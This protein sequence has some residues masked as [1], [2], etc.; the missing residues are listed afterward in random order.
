MAFAADSAVARRLRPIGDA[1]GDGSLLALRE[2]DEGVTRAVVVGSDGGAHRV[3][4]SGVE[5]PTLLAIGYVEITEDELGTPPEEDEAVEAV[6]GLRAWVGD[7]VAV[8]VPTSGLRLGW[9][10]GAAP[11]PA[12]HRPSTGA[13][14]SG[15]STALAAGAAQVSVGLTRL[16]P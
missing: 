13:V 12:D 4:G 5:L 3:A 14:G 16:V 7:T 9:A 8:E 11:A 6:A 10:S 1:A 15:F 2:D